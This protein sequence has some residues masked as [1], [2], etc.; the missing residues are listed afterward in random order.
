MSQ[1][2]HQPAETSCGRGEDPARKARLCPKHKNNK[3][4]TVNA[5]VT[6][7]ASHRKNWRSL[8]ES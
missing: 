4:S 1:K 5:K 8:L 2:S 7:L 3:R 6:S